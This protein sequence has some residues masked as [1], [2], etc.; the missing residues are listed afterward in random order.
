MAAQK[1]KNEAGKQTEPS[2]AN[3]VP[4]FPIVG[5][6]ASAGGLNAIQKLLENLPENT[7]SAF[8]VIQHLAAGQESMLPEIL[9]RSTKMPVNKVVS[10]M[11]IEID[12]VYV[13]PA[14][15]VMTINSGLLKLKPKGESFKPIDEF[16]HS[17]ASERKTQAIG[18]VLSGTGTDG[19]EG[20]KYIKAEDGITFAQDPKTAQYPDMPRSA[21]AAD[22]AYFILPPEQI[23]KELFRIAKHPEIV[24]RKVEPKELP[25][26]ENLTDIQTI[27]TLLQASFGVNF[28]NYKRS[29]VDRRIARRMV[30][31]K[32]DTQTKYIAFMRTHKEELQAL[33][34]DLLIG[35][36]GFFREPNTFELLKEKVFP[37]ILQNNHPIRVWIPG[38]S[39]GEE[40]YSLAIAIVE[41]KEENNILDHQIQIFGTDVS[42]K[43]LK[44]LDMDFT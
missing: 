43:T 4:Q 28:A 27:F 44:K 17:L 37:K 2:Q 24:R 3:T 22:S 13:I 32:I 15:A 7:G 29:T 42:E 33:F 8:I 18:V 5:I 11:P 20:L 23:A 25:R 6:G 9:S 39:T 41:F 40:V 38:C 12:H 19:T 21:I 10:G 36:T 35:V 14:G 16:F 1:N 30:L 26:E 34:D 31:N